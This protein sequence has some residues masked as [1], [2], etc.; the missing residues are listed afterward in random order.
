MSTHIS[1]LENG[2][3]H[4]FY[5]KNGWKHTFYDKNG[6]RDREWLI[7]QTQIKLKWTQTDEKD[8]E[9]VSHLLYFK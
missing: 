9:G 8:R 3:Q 2:C 1:W 4:T 6:W 5:D 7:K